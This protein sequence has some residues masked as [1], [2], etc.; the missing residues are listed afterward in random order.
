[1]TTLVQGSLL[2][3]QMAMPKFRIRNQGFGA[4]SS[5]SGSGGF[6]IH[7][8]LD[9]PTSVLIGLGARLHAP[10]SFFCYLVHL[11]FASAQ[12]SAHLVQQ[13]QFSAS[14]VQLRCERFS[15]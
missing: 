2:H 6:H 11:Q 15:R 8:G 3:V 13:A 5:S 4:S 1:M 14:H 10:T 9:W 7:F 12:E